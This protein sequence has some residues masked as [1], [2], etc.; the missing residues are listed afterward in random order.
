[1]NWELTRKTI[2]DSNQC[3]VECNGTQEGLDVFEMLKNRVNP[4]RLLMTR[5]CRLVS[6]ATTR[7]PAIESRSC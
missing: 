4:E 7:S 2:Q 6:N 3:L 1:M 5:L